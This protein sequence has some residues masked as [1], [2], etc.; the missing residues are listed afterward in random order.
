[1]MLRFRRPIRT[2]FD[3]LRPSTAEHVLAK[4]HA[5]KERFDGSTRERTF[6]PEDKVYTKL[7]FEKEWPILDVNDQIIDVDI[8]EGRR[9]R[10]HLD[11]ILRRKETV[12][13]SDLESESHRHRCGKDA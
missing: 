10:R 11:N 2:R 13:P 8:S 6:A 5:M 12:E 1:M 7:G 3:L 4:H 9:C